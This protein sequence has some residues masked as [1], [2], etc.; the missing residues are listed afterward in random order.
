MDVDC[1]TVVPEEDWN[2]STAIIS[3]ESRNMTH[4]KRLDN[5]FDGSSVCER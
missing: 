2:W 3:G 4:V 1:T 5:S